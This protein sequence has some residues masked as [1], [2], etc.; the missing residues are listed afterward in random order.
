MSLIPTYPAS[1]NAI[2]KIAAGLAGVKTVTTA[3]AAVANVDLAIQIPSTGIM[4]VLFD[5]VYTNIAPD[6][7][8]Y[9]YLRL[10]GTT[11]AGQSDAEY[12]NGA[13]DSYRVMRGTY[14]DSVVV[15]GMANRN[16]TTRW[17]ASITVGAYSTERLIRGSYDSYAPTAF[18]LKAGRVCGTSSVNAITSVGIESYSGALVIGA[19]SKITAYPGPLDLW[20]IT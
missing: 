20:G 15:I 9:M 19:G 6:A 13:G 5:I 3:G 11:A 8:Q 4:T 2:G 18:H 16:L 1:T 17:W 10:N 7:T 12:N 14:S